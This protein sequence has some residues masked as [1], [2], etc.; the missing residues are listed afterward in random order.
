MQELDRSGR[1]KEESLKAQGRLR[2]LNSGFNRA[3]K[4]YSIK[5]EISIDEA[6]L[7]EHK[8]KMK[9]DY[10][11]LLES[12]PKIAKKVKNDYTLPKLVET[13]KSPSRS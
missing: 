5:H 9:Q 1:L 10:S 6:M 12:D 13:F 7:K 3:N 4:H 2:S 8:K 11:T